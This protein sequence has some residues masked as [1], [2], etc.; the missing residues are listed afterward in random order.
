MRKRILLLGAMAV[1]AAISSAQTLSIGSDVPAMSAEKW[2]KG[3]KFE[4]FDPSKV[5]VV[6]F[7]ATWCGPCRTSIPHITELAKKYN[8]VSFTGVSVWENQK[9]ADYMA[10]VESFVKDMGSKMDYNVAADGNKQTMAAEWMTAAGEQGIPSSF[11]IKD[12]KVQWIGHPMEMEGPLKQIID[13]SFDL[14]A[15]KAARDKEMAA[16]KIQQEEQEKLMKVME[17]VNEAA[18]S[19]DWKK[20]LV[21]L[22]GVIKEN[23]DI[24]TLKM[25]RFDLLIRTDDPKVSEYALE[26]SNTIAKDNANQL[27][28]LAWTLVD[29]Q[30]KIKNRNFKI[31]TEIAEKAH[32]LDPESWMIMDTLSYAQFKDKQID[33][34]IAT[35]TKAVELMKKATG[36]DAET[37]KEILDRLELYKKAKK[38]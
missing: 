6:E 29:D 27:N 11:I 18:Q 24:S 30:V 16:Q 34:A 25:I 10:K 38:G 22:D 1:M 28:S 36:V 21:A 23:P 9:E 33:K 7:W 2:V 20:A 5:Y 3:Q 35:Q 31:A 26:L 12:N 13:G 14:A 17:P 15:A 4:K 37:R 32:K 8:Q 19:G